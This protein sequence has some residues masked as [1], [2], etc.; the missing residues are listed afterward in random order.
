M[1]HV[2]LY[3]TF[4]VSLHFLVVE[5]CVSPLGLLTQ[6]GGSNNTTCLTVLEVRGPRSRCQQDWFLLRVERRNCS[7]ILT[8]FLAIICIPWLVDASP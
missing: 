4:P 3:I 5:G 2:V 8:W 6:L 7:R 1:D